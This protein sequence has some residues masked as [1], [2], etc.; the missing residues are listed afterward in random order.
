MI[1]GYDFGRS[2]FNRAVQAERQPGSA[3]KP[4]IYGAALT[5][6]YTPVSKVIDRPVVY[7][8]PVSGF[9][10]APRNYGRKFYGPMTMRYAL[11][12]SINNAT[13]HL[14]RDLGVRYV[15]D[16]ARR[17]GIQAPLSH[18]LSLALGSSSLTLL[19]LTRAYAIYPRGGTRV[20][21][22]FITRVTDQ[23]GNELLG[24]IPLGDIPPPV[25]QPLLAK[26]EAREET[27]PDSDIMP[28]MQIISPADAYL[29][30]DLLRAVVQE[31]TGRRLR[32]LGRTLGGKTGTTNDFTDAWFMGFSP[33]LTTGVWVG[34][35]NNVSLGWGE[36]GAKA[37]LPIWHDFMKVAL[38]PYPRRDFEVPDKIEFLRIDRTSGLLAEG[39]SQDAYFQPFLEGTAPE[40]SFTEQATSEKSAQ[41]ARDDIF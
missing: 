8:D 14:F 21:P 19:E 31:G 4:F 23:A 3:F 12:K 28:T 10:W 38:A 17:M 22:R 2:E 24:D 39:N 25:L 6:G 26:G 30:S 13:V 27:Y 18:D 29:M 11:K 7:T 1:G 40:R 37:A 35:D 16:Y 34:N 15:I 32:R 20:I 36:S 9:V 41:A 5:R 33:E